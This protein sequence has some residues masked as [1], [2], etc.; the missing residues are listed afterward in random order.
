VDSFLTVRRRLRS[1]L[2]ARFEGPAETVD[3]YGDR[4]YR[5]PK[6]EIRAGAESVEVCV[7]LD[8][9]E[10]EVARGDGGSELGHRLIQI[11]LDGHGRNS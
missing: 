1:Q 4:E 6:R 9:G 10:V 3:G 8:M 5:N 2:L 11:G 7:Y